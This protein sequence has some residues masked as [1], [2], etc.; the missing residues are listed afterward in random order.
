MTG[1]I[2]IRP[3]DGGNFSIE[4]A[5]LNVKRASGCPLTGALSKECVLQLLTLNGFSFTG[6][7]AK[8][9]QNG[10]NSVM[11]SDSLKALR[12]NGVDVPT[13][14]LQARGDAASINRALQTIRNAS[15]RGDSGTIRAAALFLID[16][17]PYNPCASYSDNQRGPFAADC[18]E[19]AFRK[20]GCQAGGDYIKSRKAVTETANL[21]WSQANAKFRQMY[22]DMKSTDP[23]TQDMALKNCLGVGSE[24]HTETGETCWKCAD[25]I[26][27]P[28]R[29]NK[30]GEIECASYNGRDCLWQ[31]SKTACD[32][33][34]ATMNRA[35]LNPL[36]CGPMHKRLYGG[37]GYE[38]SG[39]WCSVASKSGSHNGPIVMKK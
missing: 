3:A 14:L 22:N 35:A 19:R 26:N 10:T 21:T 37:T 11:M 7:L 12:E 33:T 20:A 4:C 34:L 31:G 38:S 32:L 8:L 29:R 18:V 23:R 25:N 28:I 6:G 9:I 15:R 36:A 2:C 5:G 30:S 13:G 16:G 39:H 27:V 1:D 17:T 24:F